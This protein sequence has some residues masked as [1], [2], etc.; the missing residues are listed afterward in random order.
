MLTIVLIVLY[1]DI[2][3]EILPSMSVSTFMNLI[4]HGVTSP[5]DNPEL[6]KILYTSMLITVI[7]IIHVR[8]CKC[9]QISWNLI[10][11]NS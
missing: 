11:K 8:A 2:E 3:I 5:F 7:E 4:T 6:S 1:R 9:M 10:T